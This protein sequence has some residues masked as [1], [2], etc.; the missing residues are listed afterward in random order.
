MI[1]LFSEMKALASAK[2]GTSFKAAQGFKSRLF[3]VALPLAFVALTA[4]QS[5]P[6][7]GN[8]MRGAFDIGSGST[9]VKVVE[10]NTCENEVLRNVYESDEKV[11]Y[12]DDLY[13]SKNEQFSKE[14]QKEG[15]EKLLALKAKAEQAGAQKF[16][17]IAT[18][19][20]RKA[21]NGETFAS[22]LAKAAKF[23]VSVITQDREALLGAQAAKTKLK[24][25]SNILVWD[26][27][28]G[29][30]QMT[31]L[32]AN[33]ESSIYYGDLASVNFK[34]LVIEKIQKKNINKVFSPN[35]M[36]KAQ[37]QTALKIA[38]D[39]AKNSVPE[40]IQ[41]LLKN[42]PDLPVVGIGGVL[43]KSLPRQLKAQAI[44]SA[45]LDQAIE[46]RRK[47]TDK[48]LNDPYAA[49]EVTNLI[50]VKGY[51][52]ALG[53]KSVQAMDVGLADGLWF[54]PGIWN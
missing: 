43:T 50:L 40:D 44:T 52:Q 29:S 25:T 54:E 12:R 21:K 34:N 32:D 27:G 2:N 41:T 49:T 7:C 46:R 19:A 51:M 39:S 13:K 24:L 14:I 31:S 30:Q 16:T 42:N 5:T 4:C 6:K 8:E 37:V 3:N 17:G 20:F 47:L 26:I 15:T 1:A 18:A 33:A 36:T 23:P 45:L 53:I 11:D 22:Q 28:G 9:K 35:P 38:E 10:V 48:Q